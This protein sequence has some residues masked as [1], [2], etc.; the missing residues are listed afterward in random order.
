MQYFNYGYRRET[1]DYG[2]GKTPGF[3]GMIDR[4]LGRLKRLHGA[5]G[6]RSGIECN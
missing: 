5:I 6:Y 2:V 1:N 3:T 4:L